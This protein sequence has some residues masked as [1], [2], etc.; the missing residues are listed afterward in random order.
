MDALLLAAG[1]GTRLQPLTDLLPKCLMPV[2][3]KPLLGLWLEMLKSGGASKIFINLHYKAD[4]VRH[5]VENSPYHA[6]VEFLYEEDLLG[7][8]G[9][10]QRFKNRFESDILLLAHA[11]NLTL[12]DMAA[13]KRTFSTRPEGCDLTMMT[14]ET[15]MPQSC[16]IV[17]LDEQGKVTK[18][19]E[20]P[21]ENIGRLA[22]G[23]VYL[24]NF[25]ILKNI[26]DTDPEISDFSTEILPLFVGKM[27]SFH[28]HFYHR[29][30]GNIVSLSQAQTEIAKL[31]DA[32]SFIEPVKS[33][34]EGAPQNLHD[35]FLACLEN[36]NIPDDIVKCLLKP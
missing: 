35:N 17:T 13:F 23:A 1:F 14:F 21:T 6:M 31:S 33:Y 11:D 7:T 28:N 18:F 27:N 24:V 15:D 9:T 30:I 32:M 2:H 4:M 36:E 34:W 8:A 3:G 25:P 19:T 10:L 26:L 20:K 12:F 16:G 5:Y 29:D 22:N